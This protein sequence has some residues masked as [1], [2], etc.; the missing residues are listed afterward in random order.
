MTIPANPATAFKVAVPDEALDRLARR[1]ED[2][3]LPTEDIVP[4]AGW[5]YGTNLTKLRQLVDDWRRGDPRG[6]EG[7]PTSLKGNGVKDWWKHVEG[8]M[9]RH[10]HFLTTIEGVKVHFQLARSKDPN[11]IPL[12]FSHGWPGVSQRMLFALILCL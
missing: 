12:I 11:A 4:D 6:G 2:T 9:N 8:R 5:E 7:K 3:H 10:P 1:L